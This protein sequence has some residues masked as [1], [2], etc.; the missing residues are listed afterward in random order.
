MSHDAAA[1]TN[2]TNTTNNTT[3]TTNNNNPHPL[4]G[5]YLGAL[6]S[7]LSLTLNN[8]CLDRIHENELSHT[9][10]RTEDGGWRRRSKKQQ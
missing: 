7:A 3:T 8:S 10:R 1:N 4:L 6:S 2:T 5:G 9:W